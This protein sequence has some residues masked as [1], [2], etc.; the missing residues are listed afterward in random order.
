M[1]PQVASGCELHVSFRSGF[2][3]LQIV[4]CLSRST[5]SDL[6]TRVATRLRNTLE[7]AQ[8]ADVSIPWLSRFPKNCCNFTSNL[9]L[10][11][12]AGGEISPLRRMMGTVCNEKGDELGNHVWVQADEYVVDIAG[13]DFGL[14]AVVVS[15]SS[16]WHSSLQDVKPFIERIDLP[17][18]IPQPQLERLADLYA[19]VL[20]LLKPFRQE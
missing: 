12:L 4:S 20:E 6:I 3:C 2:T 15:S 8:A 14:P 13:D 16:E 18:G 11:E 10:L 9:L 19:D 5:M 1:W 7:Q 17:D